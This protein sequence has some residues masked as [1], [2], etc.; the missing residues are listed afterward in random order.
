MIKEY[1]NYQNTS[2]SY[3]TTR[4]P[5]GI[6]ILLGCFATNPRPLL[7]QVILDGGCGTGNYIQ[8]LKSKVNSLWGLEFNRGMLAQATEKF[9]N[10]PNIHLAQG[11][12]TD[13]PY[14]NDTFD[15]IMCNQVLHHLGSENA[16]GE[17]FPELN[18]AF[19]QAYRVLRPQGVF[20]CNTS[21]HQQVYD[22][23]WWADLI[24]DAVSRIAKRF[25]PITCITERLDQAGFSFGGIVVPIHA[26]M[27]GDNYLDPE[28]PLKQ[29]YRN[30]DSTWS[31]ATQAELEQALER[32]Q[33]MNKDGSI[34]QYLDHRE[35]LR[36][37]FGQTSFVYAYKK[38]S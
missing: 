32:V 18:Q 28:G 15:G 12:L 3:D 4:I 14:E 10:H 30:G 34:V 29:T 1:E 37:K 13:L 22:G 33:N 25:P 26:V 23:F 9:H 31:L 2:K 36:Q 24:P 8:A 17:N 16:A 6:E 38:Q 7:E 20:V 21:S 11:S 19:E 35:S 5:I 27:Q